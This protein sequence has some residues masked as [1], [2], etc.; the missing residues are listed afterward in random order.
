MA[1]VGT[2]AWFGEIETRFHQ[3]IA[4]LPKNAEEE[5]AELIR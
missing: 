4:H 5:R 1:Q 2:D 3:L